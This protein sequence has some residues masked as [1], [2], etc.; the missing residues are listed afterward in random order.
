MN[1][2][3]DTRPVDFLKPQQ[4]VL[5]FWHLRLPISYQRLFVQSLQPWRPRW[6]KSLTLLRVTWDCWQVAISLDSR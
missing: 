3:L 5:V 1:T 2:S 4:A 6:F